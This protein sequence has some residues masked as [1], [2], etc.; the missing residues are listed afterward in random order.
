MVTSSVASGKLAVEGG[1]PVRGPDNPFTRNSP[2]EMGPK[3]LDLVKKVLD[4]GWTYSMVADF[5]K[6]FAEACETDCAVGVSNCTAAN[7]AVLGALGVGPGDEVVVSAISDYGSIAGI[8][9][10]G[11]KIAFSDVDEHTGKTTAEEMEKVITPRTKAII[12]VHFYG[13]MCEMDPIVELGRKHGVPVIED[14]A[15]TTLGHYKGKT[16][17]SIGDIGT[18][19]FNSSKLLSTNTGGAVTTDNQELAEAVRRFAVDR[20][21]IYLVNQIGAARY[22]PGPGYNYRM[23]ELEAAVAIANL[24]TL[25]AQNERRIER[26]E[27]LSA[28]LAKIDGLTPPRVTEPGSHLYWM[29]HVQFD[30]E[31]FRVGMDEIELA[32]KAEGLDGMFPMYYLIPH[33]HHFLENREQDL[34]RLVNA[35]SHVETT[36]R[37]SWTYRM[38]DSDITDIAEVFAKVTDAYRA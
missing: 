1:T 15:Q 4:S 33:S 25:P 28:E 12:A 37:F 16:A 7:H 22:H 11:A 23:G 14:V 30:R 8:G 24:E 32:I 20:G 6:V 3:A 31:K 29:Y 10:Q 38:T 19:S 9:Y 36:F 2:R 18:F 26:G 34:A 21:A 5:E 17:G 27:K 35:R 13:Q